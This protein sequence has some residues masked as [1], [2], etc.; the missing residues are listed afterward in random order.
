MNWTWGKKKKK[1]MFAQHPYSPV[2][3][4]TKIGTERGQDFW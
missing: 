4:V 1:K 2:V 3:I